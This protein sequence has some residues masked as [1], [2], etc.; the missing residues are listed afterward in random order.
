MY[1]CS[2]TDQVSKYSGRRGCLEIDGHKHNT[3][4]NKWTENI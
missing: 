3:A 2:G 1:M 4:Y